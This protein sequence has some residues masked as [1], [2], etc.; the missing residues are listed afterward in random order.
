MKRQKLRRLLLLIALLLFPITIYYFSPYLILSGAMEGIINGSFIVF[1]LMFLFS[2]FFG[3]I[4]CSYLCPTGGLQ[5]CLISVNNKKPKQGWR[6]YIKYVIWLIWIAAIVICFINQNNMITV[7]FFY[8]TEYGI[9]V[10]N[11][12]CYIIY[13]GVLFLVFLPSAFFGRRIFCHYFCWMAPFMILGSKLGKV[14]H[15]PHLTVT[16]DSEQCVSCGTCNKNCPMGLN[17][18]EIVK[19]GRIDSSECI[20]CGECIDGC[21]KHILKYSMGRKGNNSDGK[22]EK[23]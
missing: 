4:F 19:S 14:L 5:E 22:H 8:Q 11:I 1:C 10:S 16:A 15:L 18:S 21:P 20:Q 17:V 23:T 7:D 2:M 12:Y 6:N 13:Y 3:R 9:S